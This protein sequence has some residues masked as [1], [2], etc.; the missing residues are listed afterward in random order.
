MSALTKISSLAD[1][2]EIK[3]AQSNQIA[4]LMTSKF[5]PLSAAANA[6]L[7]KP[8]DPS[9]NWAAEKVSTLLLNSDTIIRAFSRNPSMSL[10]EALAFVTKTF[11]QPF[12][13]LE[14]IDSFITK[15]IFFIRG[16]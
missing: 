16:L 1:Y 4:Q 9:A 2:F 10:P 6:Y 12:A 7:S 11:G 13:S 8:I 15:S 14:E 3:L 5:Q